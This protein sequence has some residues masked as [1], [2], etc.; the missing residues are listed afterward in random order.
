MTLK[1]IGNLPRGKLFV[2]SAPAG[3]GKTTL[4]TML[5]E[6]FPSVVQSISYTTRK[7]RGEE[8]QGAEYHFVDKATFK[9][10]IQEEAFLEHAAIYDELYG[11]SKAWVQ[12]QLNKGKHVVLVIDTQGGLQLKGKLDATFIFV[13]PPTPNCLRGRLE[14][15][16][17]ESQEKIEQRLEWAKKEIEAGK[18]YDYKIIN[19]DLKIAYQVLKSIVIA[20]EHRQDYTK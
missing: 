12:E 2:L 6:E 8:K 4:V 18:E 11:T 17:T 20:E 19:D 9:K 14:K 13:A 1:L 15:R 16:K 10:M 5:T 3:T 7:P